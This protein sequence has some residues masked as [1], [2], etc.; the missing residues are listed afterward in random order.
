M[1]SSHA[2]EVSGEV[3][4]VERAHCEEGN[5]G[6]SPLVGINPMLKHRM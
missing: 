6:P 2:E 4:P 5:G 3:W 1:G